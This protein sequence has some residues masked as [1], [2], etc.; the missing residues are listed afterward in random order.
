MRSTTAGV[1]T[2]LL[3]T[4]LAGCA[5]TSPPPIQSVA[6]KQN[7]PP[8]WTLAPEDRV[9]R[10]EDLAHW[11]KNH[12]ITRTTLSEDFDIAERIQDGLDSGANEH[13][14]FGRFEGALGRFNASVRQA[15]GGASGP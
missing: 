10:D 15:I 11:A 5:T 2:G 12:D 1:V 13:L 6:A 8:I 4:V 7:E 9:E 14:T 3:A